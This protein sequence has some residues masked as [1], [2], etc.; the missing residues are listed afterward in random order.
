MK[1]KLEITVSGNLE[2]SE[3]TQE[4][5]I[6]YII[7]SIYDID[8]NAIDDFEDDDALVIKDVDLLV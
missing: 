6:D 3:F 4:E 5:L 7:S 8:L 1:I 2:N